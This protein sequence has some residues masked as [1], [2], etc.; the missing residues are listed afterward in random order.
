MT[1]R[2]QQRRE[3]QGSL[4]VF[5]LT[6][7]ETARAC[8]PTVLDSVRGRMDRRA[9]DARIH[10]WA[11]NSVRLAKARVKVTGLE[12]F[13]RNETF[14]V[15]SNHQSNYDIFAIY[16]AYPSSLRM[17]AKQEMRSLPLLGAAMEAAEFIFVD[18][19]NNAAARATLDRAK[20]RI[21]SGIS[22]W[23]APEGTRSPT[24]E[25]GP[26][27]KGGFMLALSAGVRIL[28]CTVMGTRDVMPVKATRVRTG[29]TIQVHFHDP[30]DTMAYGLEG[31]DE[32]MANVRAA[33][34]GPL[35]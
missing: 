16:C 30:V 20:E 26:F 33:I 32:L 27:K 1:R 19:S 17:V 28:P 18:R 6:L 12:R 35:G 2:P 23:I 11:H 5:A 3:E 7:A 9:C 25:L 15:M 10:R 31:R 13:D 29:K 8:A 24:G 22:V 14:V 21:Q 34:A 4:S